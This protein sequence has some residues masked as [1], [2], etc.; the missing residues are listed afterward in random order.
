MGATMECGSSG[1]ACQF[2]NILA[3]HAGE[4]SELLKFFP[5]FETHWREILQALAALAGV[6]FG[7]WKWWFYR[8]KVLHK[9]LVEY[10]A[11]QDGR[12][13][14]TR[15][16]V[17]ERIN[18]PRPGEK[19]TTP[20]FAVPALRKVLVRQ[21]W[22]S[23]IGRIE[24]SV[25]RQL[26]KARAR[27]D[28]RIEVAAA[29]LASLQA[30]RASAHC[31]KGALSAARASNV[32]FAS[33]AAELNIAALNDFR[34]ALGVPG[35]QKDIEAK[36]C[37]A[38]QL[39][40]LDRL[41]EAEIAYEQ[42]AE[43]VGKGKDDKR[44]LILLAR[45]KRYVAEIKQAL[46]PGGNHEA[47]VAI[48]EAL[49]SWE[50]V[51]SLDAW[52]YLEF[53]DTQYLASYIR[54]RLGAVVI[55]RD[56]LDKADTAYKMAKAQTSPRRIFVSRARRLLRDSAEAGL[57][58]IGPARDGLYDAAWLHPQSTKL[59]PSSLKPP[60]PDASDVS[61]PPGHQPVQ[62]AAQQDAVDQPVKA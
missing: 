35:H 34:S 29:G 40:R 62:E 38:H 46:A 48:N 6:S 36:E 23:E 59:P 53:G 45:A 1:I 17:L 55:A 24:A 21:R 22:Y 30:Q 3:R 5:A 12:L 52:D 32:R 14:R 28:R 19:P 51:Q 8:E 58:R 60:Q 41:S 11:E 15:S 27:V 25:D 33:K 4:L 10:L 18:R 39:R 13:T 43:W 54:Y 61:Q 16:A 2:I 42:L 57:N 44:S 47:R 26:D 50:K 49:S 31:I 9:R 56:H 7:V 20:L 37:E